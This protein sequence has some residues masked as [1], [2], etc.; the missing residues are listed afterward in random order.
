MENF[1][2]L[3]NEA[4]NQSKTIIFGVNCEVNYS[5]R[6][7]A[8]LPQGDRIIIIKSD[9]SLLVHQPTGNNPVN[10]MKPNSSFIIEKSDE[11]VL[12]KS[13]NLPM[14]EYLDIFINEIHFVH[15][16]H[17]HDGQKIQLCGNE[18]DMA[19]MIIKN[20]KL[21]SEDFRPVKTEEQTKYGFID[22]LG[23]DKDNNL[24]VIE[25]KRFRCGLKDVSQ[26]RRYVE[27]VQGSRGTKKVK[28][29]LAAPGITDNA[30]KMLEDWALEY[31][32]VQPPKHRERFNKH[33]KNI[34]E[35]S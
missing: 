19:D 29:I 8:F 28:G 35:F 11:Q 16:M 24:V 25:C 26:L 9:K 10:Y 31:K 1:I 21:I 2:N 22:V 13:Q 15:T 27:K 23:R 14:K 17:L 34:S 7:E 6:A 3:V 18:K 5:G 20:P 32:Y 33:Q 12:L 4:L 30:K